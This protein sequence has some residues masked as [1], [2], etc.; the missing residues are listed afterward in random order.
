M[1]DFVVIAANIM[2]IFVLFVLCYGKRNG[3]FDADDVIGLR[4]NV[5]LIVGILIC[6]VLL[7]I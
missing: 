1:M 4:I 5:A 7:L 6:D 3:S 2:A